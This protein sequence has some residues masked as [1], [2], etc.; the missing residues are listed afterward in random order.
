MK[1]E[2]G[3]ANTNT[4]TNTAYPLSVYLWL[5]SSCEPLQLFRFLNLYRVGRTPWTRDQPVGRSLP[6][7]RTTQTQNKLTQTSMPRMGFE[8]RIPVFE[9]AK[10]VHVLLLDRATT[11]IGRLPIMLS[12]YALSS[13]NLFPLEMRQCASHGMQ[14]S[15]RFMSNVSSI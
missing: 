7:H 12:F 5:Y 1:E 8:S 9:R 15:D 4:N 13:R 3:L 10:T 2:D 6:T 11:V 14:N